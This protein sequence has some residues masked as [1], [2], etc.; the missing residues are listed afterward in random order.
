MD[1]I[2]HP[3]T[4]LASID[5]V[6]II[7]LWVSLT[8]QINDLKKKIECLEKDCETN[9]EKMKR[10]VKI[11]LDQ[12]FKQTD[13]IT[14]HLNLVGKQMSEFAN[15]VN[16]IN[17]KLNHQ[18]I[19]IKE[20]YKILKKGKNIESDCESDE[21]EEIKPKKV[22]KPNNFANAQLKNSET[23][24]KFDGKSYIPVQLNN[25]LLSNKNTKPKNT[26]IDES[27]SD[28]NSEEEKDVDLVVSLAKKN[29]NKSKK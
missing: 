24:Y 3:G 19:K 7:T 28:S 9:N 26:K 25:N 12:L 10:D 15:N 21:E 8:A 16:F 22:I 23:T 1:S 18:E 4:I 27:E 13:D 11:Q 17:N 20:M 29:N 6:A 5:L 14:K 2:K